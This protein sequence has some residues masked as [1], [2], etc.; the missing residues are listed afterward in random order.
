MLASR[1][2]APTKG[3]CDELYLPQI[4]KYPSPLQPRQTRP[5]LRPVPLQ[6]SC[7]SLRKLQE[8]L[9]HV[10]QLFDIGVEMFRADPSE[11]GPFRRR[12]G[13]RPTRPASQ[14]RANCSK[15]KHRRLSGVHN[16]G[17]KQHPGTEKALCLWYMLKSK[18]RRFQPN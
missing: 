5:F 10:I 13:P 17:V 6:G 8:Q 11:S 4:T 18:Y 2:V 3:L 1:F 7:S 16:I 14:M 9:S 15:S 12:G